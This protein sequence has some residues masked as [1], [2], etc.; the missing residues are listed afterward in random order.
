MKDRIRSR[1][2]PLFLI[3]N[4]VFI[5][6]SNASRAAW[7]QPE[8]F[9]TENGMVLLSLEQDSIP[10][11]TIQ[12]LIEAGSVFDPEGK[13]GL[14]RMTANLLERGTEKRNAI[15]ISE[16]LDF[17][18]ADLSIRTWKDYTTLRLRVLKKDIE[19]GF[20][21]L[22][23]LL[24]APG[25]ASE[26]IDRI[27]K[28]TQGA[29]L[30]QEDQ[31]G[32]V[33][34]I[35]FHDLVFD[36]H[37]YRY[38]TI[39][40]EAAI[41][42]IALGDLVAF[43]KRH[44]RPNHTILAIAGDMKAEE[45]KGF[46]E[47]YFGG[48]EKGKQPL[49]KIDGPK[50][51]RGKTIK[52]IDKNLTQ[53]TVMLGHRGIDRTHSDFYA[54]RVMNYILGG[55]G[56]SSRMMTDIRDNK[57]LVYSIY[58]HFSANRFP[59]AFSVS[60]QTKNS[61]AKEAIGAVLREIQK[62]RDAGVTTEELEEAKAYLAGSFPLKID[63]TRKMAS[64]LATIEFHGLGLDYFDDYIAKIKSVTREDVFRSALKYLSA[65]HY[66]LVVVGKQRDIDIDTEDSGMTH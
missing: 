5:M 15:A 35:A 6:Q 20:D 17:I 53:A 62:M 7:L 34:R 44:Y 8:R 55:G 46:V 4:L 59:G 41:D 21:I 14:A 58:S 48:W 27:K 12:V 31:P 47:K 64:V 23:D 66:V 45:A 56:F 52:R 65:E 11:V 22:S 57:G 63:T 40:L 25:F 38:P 13:A 24:I 61:N 18:G 49:P 37:P 3:F 19:V 2:F 16:E 10:I 33:A 50:Q 26:E 54:V 60:F 30:A 29:I 28:E 39:G 9:E 51:L 36:A 42:K 1:L 43:H 32:A